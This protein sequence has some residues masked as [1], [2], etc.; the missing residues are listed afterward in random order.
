[1]CV[2]L[3]CLVCGWVVVVVV[4]VVAVVGFLLLV[5]R[6]VD[7]V[8]VELFH[9]VAQMERCLLCQCLVCMC[10]LCLVCGRV[11]VVVVVFVVVVVVVEFLLLAFRNVDLVCVELFHSVAQVERCLL[12]L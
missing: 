8:C 11:A 9:N 7:L 3:L 5:F 10:L 6:N 4:V 12:L 2:C 1:M